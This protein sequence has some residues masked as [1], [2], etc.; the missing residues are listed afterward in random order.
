[1]NKFYSLISNLNQLFQFHIT[2]ALVNAHKVFPMSAE[3]TF[4]ITISNSPNEE[5]FKMTKMHENQYIY[6]FKHISALVRE[7]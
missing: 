3:V 6:L 7:V 5:N 4:G 2:V 1:M